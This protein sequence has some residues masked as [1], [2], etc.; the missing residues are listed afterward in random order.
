MANAEMIITQLSQY[1]RC[2]AGL[3]R[4]GLVPKKHSLVISNMPPHLHPW[5]PGSHMMWM[6]PP[7]LREGRRAV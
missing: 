3:S 2:P 6:G 5:A 7:S 1:R 4:K